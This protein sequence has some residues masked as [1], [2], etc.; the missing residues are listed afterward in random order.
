MIRGRSF[1]CLLKS[2]SKEYI[3][4]DAIVRFC[5]SCAKWEYVSVIA[6]HFVQF[7]EFNGKA[8]ACTN[9]REAATSSL[10]EFYKYEAVEISIEFWS[11]CS[12]ALECPTL[13]TFSNWSQF[14]NEFCFQCLNP[15]HWK[16]TS[17]TEF[18]KCFLFEE[19]IA[20]SSLRGNLGN[21]SRLKL[22]FWT[23]NNSI[24][25]NKCFFFNSSVLSCS[26]EFYWFIEG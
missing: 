21:L 8:M 23:F 6:W 7:P 3:F 18:R 12:R 16:M 22:T 5:T 10:T 24:L 15:L 13:C 2:I 4:T 9:V 14:Q 1:A 20:W 19:K 11:V 17:K 26:E 25:F